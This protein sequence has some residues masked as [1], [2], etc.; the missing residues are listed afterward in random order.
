[1]AFKIIAISCTA[2]S[3]LSSHAFAQVDHNTTR[4]NRTA[5]IAAPSDHGSEEA[6]VRKWSNKQARKICIK[7][8]VKKSDL[9][10][11]AK[12]VLENE[13]DLRASRGGEYGGKVSARWSR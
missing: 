5:P 11:C 7:A 9:A 6:K 10:E 4:S 13:A 8:N 2:L 1:M 12:W 3:L